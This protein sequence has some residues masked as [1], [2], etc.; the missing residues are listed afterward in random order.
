MPRRQTRGFL[1]SE[2]ND[3]QDGLRPISTPLHDRHT[4]D[5]QINRT[6]TRADE[7]YAYKPALWYFARAR[8]EEFRDVQLILAKTAGWPEARVPDLIAC[9]G[10][11]TA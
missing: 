1:I 6:V 3:D 4:I 11:A 7:G 10:E 5:H 8:V 2:L 9:Q